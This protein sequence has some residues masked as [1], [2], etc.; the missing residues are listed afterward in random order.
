MSP[1]CT[2]ATNQL[3]LIIKTALWLN[4]TQGFAEH[5]C[6]VC[7]S[8]QGLMCVL[9][10]QSL[11]VLKWICNQCFSPEFSIWILSLS[12]GQ[13]IVHGQIVQYL[14]C[15]YLVWQNRF[16]PLLEF[17]PVISVLLKMKRQTK[18]RHGMCIDNVCFQAAH[19]RQGSKWEKTT[20][21]N[22]VSCF[23][24]VIQIRKCSS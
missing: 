8:C 23:T 20:V 19:H 3:E 9:S 15:C 12:S 11:I 2:A 21:V 18:T 13:N 4:T 17:V 16:L 22:L 6:D 10:L 5:S 24:G 14:V 7:Y 1:S